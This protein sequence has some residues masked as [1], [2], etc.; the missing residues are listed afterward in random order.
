MTIR[1]SIIRACTTVKS[2]KNITKRSKIE[3]KTKRFPLTISM[4]KAAGSQCSQRKVDSLRVYARKPHQLLTCWTS[5]GI[6][7]SLQTTISIRKKKDSSLLHK[8]CYIWKKHSK[9][10][11][12]KMLETVSTLRAQHRCRRPHARLWIR[13]L[14][15]RCTSRIHDSL[16]QVSSKMQTRGVKVALKRSSPPGKREK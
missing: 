2:S 1:K 8:R 15:P 5:R 12:I 3:T 10:T 14:S 6:W 7:C 16:C 4:F 13:A 11:K 9:R